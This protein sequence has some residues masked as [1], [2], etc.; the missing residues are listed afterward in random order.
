MLM[1]DETTPAT[2]TRWIIGLLVAALFGL[3]SIVF[4]NLSGQIGDLKYQISEL[5]TDNK[6]LQR[7]VSDL[8]V[9]IQD[10]KSRVTVLVE[11]LNS[12]EEKQQTRRQ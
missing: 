12:R 6:V 2:A 10:L 7:D 11:T 8:H 4:N 9:S 3:S 5:K 1:A